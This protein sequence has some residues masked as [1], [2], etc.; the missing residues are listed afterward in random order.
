MYLN[1]FWSGPAI[2]IGNWGLQYGLPATLNLVKKNWLK[3]GKWWKRNVE[4]NIFKRKQKK[5]VPILI[6]LTVPG[7]FIKQS[8]NFVQF[9][10]ACVDIVNEIDEPK[11]LAALSVADGQ[12]K[13]K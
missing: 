4:F 11:R 5:Q 7:M 13:K 6:L 12:K 1:H 8:I 3:W 10:Q 9:K 2:P